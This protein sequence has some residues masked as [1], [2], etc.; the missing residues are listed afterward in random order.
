MKLKKGVLIM[1]NDKNQ[2]A[3]NEQR[4]PIFTGNYI[5]DNVVSEMEKATE[6]SQTIY[7]NLTKR[8]AKKKNER[9][10]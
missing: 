8:S 4:T 5:R 1:L 2:T 10:I 9:K 6:V 7:E 3:L